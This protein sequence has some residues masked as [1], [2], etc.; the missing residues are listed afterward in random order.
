MRLNSK[1][2]AVL[3]ILALVPLTGCGFLNKLQARDKLNKGVKMFQDQKYDAAAQYF[4]QA[5]ELD[6][7]FET[8]RMYLATAYTSQFIPG[9]SD[10]KSEEMAHKGIETF[11]QVVDNAKDPANPNKK[12][13]MLSIASLFYQL[14][15]YSES[16]DWCNNVLKID[17]QNAEAYY[18]IAVIDFDDSQEKTGVQGELVELMTADEKAKTRAGVDEGLTCLSKALD[19]RPT[20]FDAMEYENLLWREKA[21]FEKDEKAKEELIRKADQISMKAL[22]LKLKAQQEDAAKPKKLGTIGAGK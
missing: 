6:P 12:T 19:I 21:K 18:R 7:D 17:P 9:S 16:K 8:S 5:V 15:K 22:A 13:A 11:K 14:K 4:A 20:Y 1:W 3:L 2:L 10:P